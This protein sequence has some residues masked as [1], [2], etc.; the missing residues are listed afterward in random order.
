MVDKSCVVVD[1]PHKS[2]KPTFSKLNSWVGTREWGLG[3]GM[4]RIGLGYGL[5]GHEMSGEA[6]LVAKKTFYL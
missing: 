3:V 2:T 4:H 5:E 1:M 6:E